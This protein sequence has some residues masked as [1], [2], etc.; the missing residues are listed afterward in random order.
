MKR[1]ASMALL[2]ALLSGLTGCSGARW[3][4]YVFT[5]REEK[6]IAADYPG[7]T[8]SKVAVVVYVD[9]ST[10]FEYPRAKL[11]VAATCGAHIKEHVKGA[12]IT[13]PLVVSRY[14]DEHLHWDTMPKRELCEGLDVD[15]ATQD[16]LLV[17]MGQQPSSGFGVEITGAQMVGKTIFVQAAFSHPAPDTIVNTV[18]TT[19]WAAATIDKCA[20]GVTLRSD[21]E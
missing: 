18:I 19:P 3:L 4:T 20:P 10:Q 5:P 14:L 1:I 6:K 7:L 11:T 15:F 16:V 9:E 12:V 8:N 2:A 21:Y 17:G 13:P